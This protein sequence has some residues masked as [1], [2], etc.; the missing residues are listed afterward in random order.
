M[1]NFPLPQTSGKN[2]LLKHA[3]HKKINEKTI[4]EEEFIPHGSR[5]VTKRRIR[6]LKS[7]KC[8][9]CKEVL[10]YDGLCEEIEM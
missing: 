5:I 9:D 7:V 6:V 3:A 2:W 1:F 4:I 8:E 10:F